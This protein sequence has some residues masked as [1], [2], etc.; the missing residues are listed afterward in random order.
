VLL[1]SA[2][3]GAVSGLGGFLIAAATDLPSGAVIV[4]VSS[5]L[6]GMAAVLSRIGRH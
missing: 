4:L 3:F 2:V 1:L 6:V 5:A